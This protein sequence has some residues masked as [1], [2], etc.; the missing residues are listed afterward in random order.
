MFGFIVT[1]HYNNYETIKKCLNLLFD[2]ISLNLSYIILYVNETTCQKVLNIKQ[3]YIDKYNNNSN[4]ILNF[5][6]IYINNQTINGGLTGTWNLGIDYLLNIEFFNC[7]VVTILGHDTFVNKDIKYL[8]HSALEAENK[9]DL[10]YFGPLC[11][12]Y[13]NTNINLWQDSILYNNY[14]LQYLTGFLLTIPVN[15]LI[16]NKLN[17]KYYFNQEQYPFAGNEVDWYNRFKKING[18]AILC[19]KCIIDHEHN[20]SWLK[21]DKY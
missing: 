21:I 15:S 9:K 4:T 14:E 18:K 3:E 10:K 13:N 5:E 12:S 16:E 20:R 19:E 6:V 17:I 11:R 2:S 1:T 8:L 7:K